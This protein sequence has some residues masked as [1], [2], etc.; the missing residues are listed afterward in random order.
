MR[1]NASEVKPV[2]KKRELPLKFKGFEGG[3][4]A[5]EASKGRDCGKDDIAEN[6][7]SDDAPWPR[8]H[9]MRRR[10]Q[11]YAVTDAGNEINSSTKEGVG[12]EALSSLPKDSV[13][14]CV[15]GRRRN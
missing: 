12:T 11:E 8:L 1:R 5:Q 15:R 7:S 2:F 9:G 13:S 3:K 6:K 4:G 14:S 10:N